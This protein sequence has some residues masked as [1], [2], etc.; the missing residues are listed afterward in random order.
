MSPTRK[1]PLQKK[2]EIR[3]WI[4]LGVLLLIS[5]IFASRTFTL[6]VLC[7]GVVSIANYYWLYLSLK[8]AFLQVS[9]R[10]KTFIMI[11]YYLRFVVTGIA[12]FVLIT[13]VPVSI[14]GLIV[15]L[16][17]VVITI[18]LTTLLEVSKKN[19]FLKTTE[20]N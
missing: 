17:V 4:V 8:K 9:D 3:N 18:V 7:G 19:F 15:G 11:R 10:T 2:I 1:D 20:V 12:L 13:Q 5:F 16:S 14:V 6:G